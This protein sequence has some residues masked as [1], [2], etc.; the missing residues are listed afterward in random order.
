MS[1]TISS[2]TSSKP[3]RVKNPA[4]KGKQFE[5]DVANAIAHIFPEAQR[6]LEYQASNVIGVDIE[7]T[8]PFLIQ[9]KNHANY[10]SVGTINEVRVQNENQIPV[11]VTK[12]IRLEA[13]AVLPFEKFVTLLEVAYGLRPRLVQQVSQRQAVVESKMLPPVFESAGEL[14]W[15]DVESPFI[16]PVQEEL[17]TL[18]LFI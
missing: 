7:G 2:Q 17:N 8:D 16:K 13:M 11:L 3:K 18:E 6:M 12:G 4:A 10:C 1:K 15:E 9:C 14:E 5:R